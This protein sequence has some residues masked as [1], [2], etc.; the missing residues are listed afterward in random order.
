[1]SLAIITLIDAEITTLEKARAVLAEI[2]ADVRQ[3]APAHAQAP[4]QTEK[5]GKRIM[6]AEGRARVAAAQKKRW[7]RLKKAKKAAEK[8]AVAA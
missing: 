3:S 6:S 7:A 2:D 5:G 1:M 8:V 4:K